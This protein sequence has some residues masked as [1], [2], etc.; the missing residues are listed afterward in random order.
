MDRQG[1]ECLQELAAGLPAW[2]TE[3][4]RAQAA[5]E[6]REGRQGVRD[7]GEGAATGQGWKGRLESRG[8]GREG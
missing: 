2:E 7:G 4:T 6:Q 5:L 1:S 8:A 3:G